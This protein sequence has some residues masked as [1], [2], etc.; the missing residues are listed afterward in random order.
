V[1]HGQDCHVLIPTV[2]DVQQA[3]INSCN[4]NNYNTMSKI[5]K[6]NI[7]GPRG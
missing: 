1:Q 5:S 4:I 2:Y 7:I 3:N 6:I